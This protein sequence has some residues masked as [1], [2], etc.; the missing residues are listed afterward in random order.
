MQEAPSP[1][2]AAEMVLVRL[3]YVADLPAPAELVRSLQ[4]PAPRA[5]RTPRAPAPPSR[6]AGA[7]AGCRGRLRDRPPAARCGL[8]SSCAEAAVEA[9]YRRPSPP[10][11][12]LEPMPQSFAEVVALF[13]KRREAV[14]RSHLAA[15]LH[16]VHF[17]PGRI[18]FRP[19]DGRAARPRQPPR[20]A[21]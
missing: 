6:R 7:G 14:L 8:R 5:R 19:A 13:D 2:Q 15:H 12:A 11:A 4:E 21:A 1:I 16:L 3:A 17:E 18:E 9:G 10:V 20:P